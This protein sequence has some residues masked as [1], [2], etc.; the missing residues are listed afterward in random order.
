MNVFSR[1]CLEGWWMNDNTLVLSFIHSGMVRGIG[2]HGKL[3]PGGSVRLGAREVEEGERRVHARLVQRR[4][5]R[6]H[7]GRRIKN[8]NH[9]QWSFRCWRLLALPLEHVLHSR[10]LAFQESWLLLALLCR[11]A[12]HSRALKSLR[13]CRRLL[14]VPFGQGGVR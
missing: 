14:A 3:C 1:E 5:V 8:D 11:Q 10:A 7:V 2:Y 9:L 6:L 4:P 13:R 12:L